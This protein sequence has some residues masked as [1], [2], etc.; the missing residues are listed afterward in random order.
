MM[1]HEKRERTTGRTYLCAHYYYG[2]RP[3]IEERRGEEED[4]VEPPVRAAIMWRAQAWRRG[5]SR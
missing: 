3:A 4:G 1:T 2:R 5:M